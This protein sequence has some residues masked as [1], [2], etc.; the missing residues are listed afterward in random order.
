M[1]TLILLATA[2]VLPNH[3]KPLPFRRRDFALALACASWPC[4][5]SPASALAALTSPPL[6]VQ[7]QYDLPRN[8]LK[9]SSF[10]RGMSIGM[11]SYE[12]AVAPKKAKLFERLLS[13]LPERDAV[14]VELGIGEHRRPESP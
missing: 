12:A 14:I 4:S 5:T 7:T 2:V 9:D 8:R 6:E 11:K 13:N 1:T 10:A 3:L